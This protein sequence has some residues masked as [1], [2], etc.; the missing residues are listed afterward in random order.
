MKNGHGER[1]QKL[2]FA[3]TRKFF[4]STSTKRTLS[5]VL[6]RFLRDYK[7]SDSDLY[8]SHIA[9][10]E[11]DGTWKLELTLRSRHRKRSLHRRSLARTRKGKQ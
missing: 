6:S 2:T 10:R 8:G 11:K 7:L 9:A 5:L 4:L 1:S 3:A